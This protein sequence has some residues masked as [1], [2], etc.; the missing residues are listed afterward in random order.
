MSLAAAGR[1]ALAGDVPLADLDAAA[2]A[3]PCRN[4]VGD[5]DRDRA[6]TGCSP[7]ALRDKES[8]GTILQRHSRRQEGL[9]VQ[10]PSDWQA[11]AGS[12]SSRKPGRQL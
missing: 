2:Q 3:D 9:G 12:P 1:G 7:G 5:R 6:I 8:L 10:W 11:L 4:R